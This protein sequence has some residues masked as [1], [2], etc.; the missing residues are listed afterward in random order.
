MKDNIWTNSLTAIAQ[1]SE[2]KKLDDYKALK[3]AEIFKK[4]SI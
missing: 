1:I 3:E 2:L 4:Y